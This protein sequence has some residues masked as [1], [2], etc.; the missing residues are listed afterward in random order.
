MAHRRGIKAPSS[1]PADS[2]PPAQQGHAELH[3]STVAFIRF[4]C[5]TPP[6][7][8]RAPVLCC[9]FYRVA[10]NTP[11]SSH[12]LSSSPLDHSILNDAEKREK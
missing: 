12:V 2:R 8:Y 7:T 11:L 4:D 1:V 10:E 6:Q 3:L 9:S 5:R